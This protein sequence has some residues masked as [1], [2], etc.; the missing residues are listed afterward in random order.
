MK[1]GGR[2]WPIALIQH[3]TVVNMRLSALDT[4]EARLNP[5]GARTFGVFVGTVDIPVSSKL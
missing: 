5:I 1:K 4:F 2:N 3:T